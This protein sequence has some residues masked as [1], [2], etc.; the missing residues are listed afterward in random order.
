VLIGVILLI[1][2]VFIISLTLVVGAA[3]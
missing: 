3:K 2:A 1:L